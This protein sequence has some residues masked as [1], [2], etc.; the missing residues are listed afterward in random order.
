[1]T[2]TS[3]PAILALRRTRWATRGEEAGLIGRE[4]E[5][6]ELREALNA[7][8]AGA[9]GLVLLAGEAGVGK[10]RLAE[11]ALAEAGLAILR[12]DSSQEA[13]APY[14]PLV[15]ALRS[16]LHREPRGLD[17]CG[18]MLPYLRVLLPE[19]GKP[20]RH[21]D[22]ATL[23][24]AIRTAL[25]V[26]GRRA[27]AAVLL[28]DLHWADATTLELLAP[29]AKALEDDPVLLVGAYRNDEIP[30]GHPLRALR[31]ELRR[32]GRLFELVLGPLDV[33]DT[34]LL[35][36]RV[37][38][39][40]PARSLTSA[41]YDRTQGVPFFIEELL[42]ALVVSGRL[43]AGRFGVE[44]VGAD[45]LP[46]PETVRDAVLLRA[47][48]L[49]EGA[50]RLL[51]TAAV[52]GVRCD[53]DLVT[54]LAGESGIDELLQS[55]FLL[56][57]VPGRAAFRHS[58]AREAVYGSISWTQRRAIHA[59]LATALEARHAPPPLIA[60]H[61]LSARDVVRARPQ[62]VAAFDEACAVHAHRDALRLGRR[63]L[64]LWPEGEDADARLELLARLG[65][66]AELSGEL[67]EAVRSWSEVAS[68]RLARGDT[69]GFAEAER[70]RANAHAMQGAHDRALEG[71]R[72]AAE[73]F[74]GCGRPAEAAA[75]LLAAASHLDSAGRLSIALEHVSAAKAY[76]E[77]AG[78][79]DLVARAL[80]IEGTARAKLGQI[81]EALG[82]ARAGLALA[83]EHDVEGAAID[84][85]QRLAN[86]LENATDLPEAKEAYAAAHELCELEGDG[87]SGSVCLI[88][89]AY[90]LLQTGEWDRCLE[91]DRELIASSAT[92]AGVRLAAKQHFAIVAALRGDARRARRLYDQTIGYAELHD[93]QRL[94]I[95]EPLCYGWIDE[96]EGRTAD[97]LERCREIVARWTTIESRHYPLPALRWA[98]T[99]LALHGEE[100]DARAAAEGIARLVSGTVSRE[101]LATFAH[102]LGEV[103]LLDGD[104]EQASAHFVQAL[105]LLSTLELP[106]ETAQTRL[107]A[108]AALAVAGDREAAVGFVT[109]AY[110]TARR[111]G[112]RPLATR[113]ALQLQE[114]GE[115]V[116]DRLGRRAA[117]D[118][119]RG[120]LTRR[121]LDVLRL[122]AVGRTNRDVAGALYLSPRTVD[123]HV[124]N[125]LAKLGCRSRTEAASRAAELDLLA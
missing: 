45:E 9:G 44:L 76:A 82:A 30:R 106:Y 58:L 119:E 70:R 51:E 84:A 113:C 47:Q 111:L 49:S 89:I 33:D 71:R 102:A 54:E 122:V 34:R 104:A 91:L 52:A 42:D 37:L 121:E 36:A 72:A 56:E 7:A 39:L 123:M 93:R 125:L 55:E 61:W 4:R 15:A 65:D 107:R 114:W 124:R 17:D 112:A 35:A 108:G 41:L 29:L 59:A 60:E 50:R 74:A 85:Y 68:E 98:T 83:L 80:G 69:A 94:L 46:I 110:R 97:A 18:P 38:D 21:A 95:W 87:A 88:C 32:G 75:E 31:S 66:C 77:R 13:P 117:G 23:F 64:E 5:L 3:E 103:A 92:P 1:M 11:D 22:R 19:L 2:N 99:F 109:A 10:T 78:R 25:A 40:A 100:A 81:E 62:L 16:F 73:A 120:G 43:H 101:A 79:P 67:A 90:I 6:A 24:E 86:V 105:D 27:P 57:P 14:G 53:V 118:A 20:V 96:L 8:R 28:D 26:V 48:R 12:G 115:P 63:V 116:E